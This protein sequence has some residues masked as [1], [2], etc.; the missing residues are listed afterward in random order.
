MKV[1]RGKVRKGKEKKMFVLYE[2]ELY[3]VTKREEKM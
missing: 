2:E 3:G 1:R